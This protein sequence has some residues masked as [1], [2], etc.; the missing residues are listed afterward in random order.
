MKKLS[1]RT[2]VLTGTVAAGALAGDLDEKYAQAGVA[3]LAK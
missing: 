2:R 3:T 1:L